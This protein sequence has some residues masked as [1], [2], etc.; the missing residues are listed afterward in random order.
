MHN[1][2]RARWRYP[3]LMM[4]IPSPSDTLL[5]RLMADRSDIAM[6]RPSDATIAA[7]L[8]A[9]TKDRQPLAAHAFSSSTVLSY[10]SH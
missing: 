8:K 7:T 6:P 2:K 4:P 1:N 9:A 10:A 3:H 5:H